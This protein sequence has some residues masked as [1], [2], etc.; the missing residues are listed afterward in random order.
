MR[1]FYL[2][3]DAEWALLRVTSLF[4]SCLQ[5]LGQHTLPVAPEL[6]F[7][8]VFTEL[9]GNITTIE[10]VP[11]PDTCLQ[12]QLPGKKNEQYGRNQISHK[13]LY[14]AAEPQ[15]DNRSQPHYKDTYIPGKIKVR[16]QTFI[17]FAPN[18]NK[19]DLL[20]LCYIYRN[21]AIK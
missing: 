17:L 3:D 6:R 13:N 1:K 18:I 9:T 20:H 21:I 7:I 19:I 12:Q 4:F 10:A 15:S 11:K 2:F 5:S 14:D 8:S 16:Y